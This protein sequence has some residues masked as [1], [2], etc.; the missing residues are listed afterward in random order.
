MIKCR[1]SK[2]L[3]KKNMT[4]TIKG[5]ISKKTGKAFDAKVTYDSTQKSLT[6]IK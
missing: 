1:Y 2:K 3:L 6:F 4:D 5:F